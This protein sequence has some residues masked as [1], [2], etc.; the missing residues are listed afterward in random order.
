MDISGLKMVALAAD[1]E[2]PAPLFCV[3]KVACLLALSGKQC[4]YYLLFA[5]INQSTKLYANESRV[6]E[7]IS[8]QFCHTNVCMSFAHFLPDRVLHTYVLCKHSTITH[9]QYWITVKNF[10]QVIYHLKKLRR[11]FTYSIS[12]EFLIHAL[13][14]FKTQVLDLKK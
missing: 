7:Y 14:K 13:K 2:A 3:V 4:I 10:I 1:H 6:L 11:C 8:S 9:M 12:F 5:N